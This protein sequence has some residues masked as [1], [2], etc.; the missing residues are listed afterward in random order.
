MDRLISVA[1]SHAP[2]ARN[3]DLAY[4]TY[5]QVTLPEVNQSMANS[6]CCDTTCESG[7]DSSHPVQGV[8][9][10]WLD[11]PGRPNSFTG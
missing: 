11:F 1:E 3:G 7:N 2:L 4:S 8:Y 5:L 10:R 6:N 9:A